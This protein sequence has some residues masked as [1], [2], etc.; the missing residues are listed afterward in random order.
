MNNPRVMKQII[1]VLFA[2]G[3]AATL[4]APQ[5]QQEIY[6]EFE[7]LDQA[8]ALYNITDTTT[9]PF[10]YS[11]LPPVTAPTNPT[12]LTDAQYWFQMGKVDSAADQLQGL[13][14][15]MSREKLGMT[16]N[17]YNANNP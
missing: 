8:L 12:N 3:V 9:T 1:I 4:F 16:I 11:T 7:G 5:S 17:E 10:D 2:I 15:E 6:A 13:L 14:D